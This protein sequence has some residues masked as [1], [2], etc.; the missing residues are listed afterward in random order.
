MAGPLSLFGRA[1]LGARSLRIPSD[2]QEVGTDVE[3]AGLQFGRLLLGL[4]LR[5]E[6]PDRE[7]FGYAGAL[8][9]S[10]AF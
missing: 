1:R 6:T 8:V 3:R 7:L 2:V 5:S 9:E 4:G 10:Q